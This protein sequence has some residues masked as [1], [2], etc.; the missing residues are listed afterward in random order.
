MP[1]IQENLN[2]TN[3]LVMDRW[4]VAT[5][6]GSQSGPWPLE[7]VIGLYTAG[8]LDARAQI[9]PE[10]SQSWIP[11]ARVLPE[12]DISDPD[13][14]PFALS[15]ADEEAIEEACAMQK[16]AEWPLAKPWPTEATVPPPPLFTPVPMART[17]PPPSPPAAHAIRGSGGLL[18]AALLGATI[19]AVGAIGVWAL[20]V[21]VTP[22]VTTMHEVALANAIRASNDAPPSTGTWPAQGEPKR[23]PREP[24]P[25]VCD[26]ARSVPAPI[27]TWLA[28]IAEGRPAPRPPNVLIRQFLA[29]RGAAP[30]VGR[31][32][33][34]LPAPD[35]GRKRYLVTSQ[36]VFGYCLSTDDTLERGSTY[37]RWV[38]RSRARLD[39][40]Q[41]CLAV[42]DAPLDE[43]VNALAF[44]RPSEPRAVARRA[45]ALIAAA[46]RE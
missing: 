19:G 16:T 30:T 35:G 40:G 7:K 17:V 34:E 26:G 22:E 41:R 43:A 36:N 32:L 29:T 13:Q 44:G 5:P 25:L 24:A 18:V 9:R 46:E 15:S 28:G 31:V 20:R 33:D 23:P 10:G 45:V 37:A 21:A 6:V 11:I 2:V 3:T 38:A 14:T 8:K 27:C 12:S 39:V 1:T 4:W 42:E